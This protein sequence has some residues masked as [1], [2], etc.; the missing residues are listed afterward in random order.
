MQ[1]SVRMILEAGGK[2][3]DRFCYDGSALAVAVQ[4]DSIDTARLLVNAGAGLTEADYF[5]HDEMT[6]AV[7]GGNEECIQLILSL[8]G[9]PYYVGKQKGVELLDA[10]DDDELEYV[11]ELIRQG[12]DVNVRNKFG[13]TA[14][15]IALELGVLE[16]IPLLLEAGID[17]TI[18]DNNGDT[19]WDFSVKYG[20][21]LTREEAKRIYSSKS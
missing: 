19:A 3:D 16:C 17:E 20:R 12:S 5:G 18:K 6:R 2:I 21:G 7:L 15:F 10:I 4:K 13:R 11:N 1:K 9:D 8:D 14:L